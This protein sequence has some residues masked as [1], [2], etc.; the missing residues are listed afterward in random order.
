MLIFIIII[1]NFITF[2]NIVS[3]CFL[4][5]ILFVFILEYVMNVIMYVFLFIVF[6]FIVIYV[7]INF[8]TYSFLLVVHAIM[9]TIS[10][11]LIG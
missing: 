2:F 9:N 6:L 11:V 7:F 4:N 8:F 5:V 1:C 3:S 10:E